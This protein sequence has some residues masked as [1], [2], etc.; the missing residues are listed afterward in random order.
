MTLARLCK[1]AQLSDFPH[2]EYMPKWSETVLVWTWLPFPLR[3][4]SWFVVWKRS[5]RALSAEAV[6]ASVSLSGCSGIQSCPAL[7]DPMDCSTPGFLL[8]HLP[9]FAQT[10]VHWVSDIIQASHPLLPTSPALNL[11]QHQSLFKWVSS[12]H[13]V[14]KVLEL[15][16]QSFQW[17]FRF[18]LGST[19]WISLQSKGTF[20]SLL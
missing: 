12:S 3:F 10:H 18:P 14:A 7:R 17:I 8:H 13:Q 19:S 1:S 2:S 15:Q 20:K 11:S 4:Y 5:G 6:C 16:R 9:E